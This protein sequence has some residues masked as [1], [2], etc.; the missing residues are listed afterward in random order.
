MFPVHGDRRVQHCRCKRRA[1]CKYFIADSRPGVVEPK[2]CTRAGRRPAGG[3]WGGGGENERACQSRTSGSTRACVSRRNTIQPLHCPHTSPRP[4]DANMRLRANPQTGEPWLRCNRTGQGRSSAGHEEGHT[5]LQV[6]S[7]FAYLA[8]RGT[9]PPPLRS[10]S[11][12]LAT[13]GAAV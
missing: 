5:S 9:P 4:A 11:L 7:C 8:G 3:K 1:V 2:S 12:R 10:F 6:P 13:V